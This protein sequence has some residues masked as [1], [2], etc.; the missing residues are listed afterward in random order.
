M[1][2]N[3]F[4]KTLLASVLGCTSLS[5]IAAPY[6]IIDLGKITGGSN[7]FAYGIND[8]GEVVGFADGPLRAGSTTLRE[9]KRHAV[10]F[11]DTGTVTD[12]GVL[13][14][15]DE[16]FAVSI[17]NSG[18]VVGSS[19]TKKVN[20]DSNGNSTTVTNFYPVIFSPTPVKM[21][22]ITGF[23]NPR[24][25]SINDNGIVVGFGN[26]DVNASDQ[27]PAVSRG[28]VYNTSTSQFIGKID[29]LSNNVARRSALTA[30]NNNGDFVGWAEKD[31][32]N[33]LVQRAIKGNVVDLT[34]ITELP[35]LET[36]LTTATDINDSGMIVGFARHSD[37]SNRVVAVKYASGD[38]GLVKLPF[39]EDRYDNSVA[40]AINNSGQ[41]VG[42]A[43]VS[44]PTT[45]LN[46]GFIYEDD[47]LKNLNTLIPCKS[48]WRIDNATNINN[49]GDIIGYGIKNNEVRAFKLKPTGGSVETCEAESPKPTQGGG[50]SSSWWLLGLLAGL[51]LLV[52][53]K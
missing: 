42:Q 41:I 46:A 49:N 26:I 14:T 40:N 24:A 5:L 18:V 32:G 35:N 21:S 31:D 12:L 22:P 52:R 36:I 11:S 2:H 39:F 29:D 6:E 43:L 13:D 38:T 28:F 19:N 8:A 48:G 45:G 44:T 16:S 23:V 27:V 10:K 47:T 50:G 25:I 15:G 3:L 9:F 34:K 1:R 7:S 17:N 4:R 37:K 51:G 30:I 53:R 33:K 20:T